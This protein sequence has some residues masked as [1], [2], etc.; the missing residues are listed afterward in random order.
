[1]KID[2]YVKVKL[3]EKLKPTKDECLGGVWISS[4]RNS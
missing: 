4:F 1:M 3:Y 2:E